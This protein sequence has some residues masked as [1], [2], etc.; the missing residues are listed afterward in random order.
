MTFNLLQKNKVYIII[1]VI[2]IG[3]TAVN[4]QRSGGAKSN[5]VGFSDYGFTF[6]YPKGLN[7][8]VTGLDDE[9]VFDY[10]GSIQAS[11]SSG[12]FGFNLENNEFALTWATLEGEPSLEEVLD[13]HFQSAEINS[14]RRGRGI[15]IESDPVSYGEVNG[16]E[17][18][19]Q[20]HLIE[21]DMPDM[22]D[23]LYA[24]G[25]VAAWTCDVTGVSYDFYVLNWQTGTSPNISDARLKEYLNTYIDIM[26]CH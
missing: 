15:D 25:I 5:L 11:Q 23:P 2:I 24:K 8:W 7:P 14:I 19:Y 21:L 3:I 18:A 9:N 4:Y 17:A 22:D 26:E 10:T 1:A 16:H 20:T 6:F 12:M 13:I